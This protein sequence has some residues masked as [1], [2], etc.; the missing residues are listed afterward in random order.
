MT[1]K[2]PIALLVVDDDNDFRSVVVRRFQRRGF[3]VADAA[4]PSEALRLLEERHF[5]VAILDLAMPE[6]DGVSLLERLRRISP[7]TQAIMLTGQ[8]TMETAIRA[9]KLGAYDYLIKPCELAEL[10]VQV[11]RAYEKGQLTRENQSL[12]TMLRRREPPNAIIGQSPAVAEML[13]LIHKVAPTDSSVLI[14]GESGTGK[15]LVARAIHQH[16]PR[17]DRPLVAINCAALQEN[18]LESEL[19][20][21]EQGAFTSAIAAKEGL[22]EVADQSTLFIDEIGEMSMALQAK[23]LRVLEDGRFRRVG[24]TRETRTDVRIVAATNKDLAQEVAAHR[25]RPDLYYRLNVFA[26]H[27]PPLRERIEDVPLLVEHFLKLNPRSATM[28]APDALRALLQYHWPGNVR[29][30]ANVIERAKILA[31]GS[32]INLVDLPA[33]ITHPSLDGFELKGQTAPAAKESLANLERRHI[34]RALQ[35]EAGNKARAARTLGISRRRLYR[36]LEK[37][38]LPK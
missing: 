26:I 29:E 13:Q 19:F 20:G 5:D 25:F 12:K 22:F 35:I 18:L 31:E 37:H 6:Q 28:I 36:L 17:A 30:L 9:M 38:A 8:G 1:P 4:R 2:N 33:N 16:S 23:L 14:L 7:T 32:T 27:V 34:E 15:E 24:S 10:E 11:Q 21:H 3:D